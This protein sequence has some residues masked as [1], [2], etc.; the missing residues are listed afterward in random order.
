MA[1]LNPFNE[2][3]HPD[4]N[5]DGKM[6]GTPRNER[7]EDISNKIREKRVEKIREKCKD[8]DEPGILAKI[9]WKIFRKL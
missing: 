7:G 4:Y 9:V 5:W 2:V 1:K 8:D 6:S 3:V